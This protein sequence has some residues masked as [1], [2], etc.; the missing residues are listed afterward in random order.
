MYNMTFYEVK[1]LENGQYNLGHVIG[2][3]DGTGYLRFLRWGGKES[4]YL[5]RL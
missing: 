4:S 2:G 3:E 1:N 5:G